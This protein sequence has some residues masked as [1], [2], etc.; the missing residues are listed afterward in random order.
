[1]RATAQRETYSPA[2]FSYSAEYYV[3]HAVQGNPEGVK[4][5]KYLVNEEGKICWLV[6]PGING[7]LGER[8]NGTKIRQYKQPQ[9]QLFALVT[10]GILNQK[11]PWTLVVLGAIIAAVV[12]LCG[13]SSLAFAVGMYLPLSSSAPIFVGGVVRYV[14]DRMGRKK[15]DRPASELESEMS[16]GMLLST[17]YIAGGSIAGVL[18]SFLSFSDTLPDAL[19]IGKDLPYQ[20]ITA[21]ITFVLLAVFL[22]LVGRGWLLK[23]GSGSSD[24]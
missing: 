10:D 11:L 13:V 21:L 8:D 17:G 23:T 12:E 20:T 15:S 4:P 18:V 19:A 9:A 22:V 2:E 6:D 14:V 3:W 1:L 7:R 16:P 5:G 24:A